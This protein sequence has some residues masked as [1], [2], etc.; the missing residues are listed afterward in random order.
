MDHLRSKLIRLAYTHP[1]VRPHVLP[2]LKTASSPAVLMEAARTVAD[3]YS[4]HP[5]IVDGMAALKD[6]IWSTRALIQ[7]EDGM[8]PVSKKLK[9]VEDLIKK[10]ARLP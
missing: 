5:D 2:I 6:L 3:L 10:L 4:G 8:G 9:E 7:H 1:E